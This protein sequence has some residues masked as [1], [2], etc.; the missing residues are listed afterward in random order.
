VADG[1]VVWIQIPKT[2]NVAYSGVGT[3]AGNYRV[4]PRGE[5]P[6]DDTT[7]WLA[8]REGTRLY[9]R[10][11][12]EL[13]AGE[14]Q[15]ISD[16]MGD[17]LLK[18]LGFNPETATSVP[19]TQFPSAGLGNS[20]NDQTPVV[21]ALSANTG[22]INQLQDILSGN[23]YDESINYLTVPVSGESL[24]VPAGT[25][26]TLP[27]DTRDSNTAKQ[28][29]VG[30]AVLEMRLNTKLLVRGVDYNE[31]GTAGALSSTI[32]ILKDIEN[33]DCLNFRIDTVGGFVITN[34]AVG[35]MSL[36]DAYNAGRVIATT[37]NQPVQITGP[38]SENILRV[39][40][41]IESTGRLVSQSLEM[42]RTGANPIAAAKDGLYVD[43]A[44]NL[45]YTR[46][47]TSF[48]I[49][50]VLEGK[51]TSM[52]IKTQL[53]NNSGATIQ[54]I[55]PIRLNAVGQLALIDPSNQ[56]QVFDGIGLTSASIAN[57][58]SGDVVTD[59]RIENVTTAYNVGSTLYVSKIGILTDQKPTIGTN[60]FV[61]GDY[62]VVAAK[63]VANIDTPANKDVIVNYKIIGTL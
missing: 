47:N 24:P 37:T 27:N 46:Q 20:F 1:E 39:L 60:G 52:A 14:T 45:I 32:E 59:G 41:N 4:T 48:N 53:I 42:E 30:S 58:T 62:I 5:V 51:S 28:Y 22:N 23:V 6:L 18:Y 13:E 26:I 7:Y 21:E 63:V 11:L 57:G 29:V 38:A 2:G 35:V 19:Y 9:L 16:T 8:Y 12:G 40:G 17:S 56:D 61:S 3:A 43:A 36:Q 15:Q 50:N 55:T 33:C 34:T 10:G 49:S 54:P 25:T 44:G 31:V